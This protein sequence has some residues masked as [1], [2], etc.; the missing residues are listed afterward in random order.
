MQVNTIFATIHCTNLEHA[1]EWY[2]ALFD[3]EPDAAPMDGLKEWHLGDKAGLQLVEDRHHAGH[4]TATLGVTGI[5][6]F[7]KRMAS[8][9]L[10]MSDIQQGDFARILTLS[11]PD[12]NRIVLAERS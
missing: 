4:G 7:A 12:D 3:R 6:G 5:E 1:T 2:T 10:P 9:G 11:D 8:G